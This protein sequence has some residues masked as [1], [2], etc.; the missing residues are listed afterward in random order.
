M[1]E[2]SRPRPQQRYLNS[3]LTAA[4]L[5]ERV[6]L[7]RADPPRHRAPGGGCDAVTAD[8][9]WGEGRPP[10]LE[11][12]PLRPRPRRGGVPQRGGRDGWYC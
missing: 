3:N 4:D 5:A 9:P 12:R 6:R 2:L 8:L 10:R 1:V 7:V 11:P